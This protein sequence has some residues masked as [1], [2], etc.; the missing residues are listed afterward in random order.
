[1]SRLTIYKEN[2]SDTVAVSNQFIDHYLA[3]ANDAQI[4]V[5]LYLLR[6]VTSAIPTSISDIADKFNHTERD[7]MRALSYWEKLGLIAIEYDAK[8]EICG[9]QIPSA[10]EDR[11]GG[12]Q[13]Y[14]MRDYVDQTSVQNA[15]QISRQQ[16]QTM[17]QQLAAGMPAQPLQQMQ[18]ASGQ[19][20]QSDRPQGFFIEKR[21]YSREEIKALKEKEDFS[22][23]LFATET[24][25]A[26][27]LTKTDLQTLAFISDQLEF[28]PDLL[29][30]LVEYCVGKDH[31]DMHYIEKVAIAWKQAGIK[32]VRQAKNR[33]SRYE[34]IVYSVMKAL[35]RGQ[36]EVTQT[37]ADYILGWYHGLGFSEEVILL[38][39]QKAVLA[40]E[41][42][43]IAYTDGI[44]KNWH[45]DGLK[46]TSQI[47]K[48]E[49]KRAAAGS[50]SEG[51]PGTGIPAKRGNGVK[52]ATSG[53]VH[54][55]YAGRDI[56]FDS[57]E[58]EALKR[59]F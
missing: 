7:V 19:P 6:M 13:I 44:L 24:Y 57:L 51:T 54:L 34:K 31:R 48:A 49:E 23:V 2:A 47:Q 59:S 40:T 11:Q 39:C 29:E 55:Q 45:K 53:M 35:G 32:T 21:E 30:Y 25:F 4:K 14:A 50:G 26:R 37:E 58:K 28:S 10:G 36:N 18:A 22:Q 33:S 3:D 38:A 56:D 1:M 41:S 46:T 52:G 43:R 16:T 15:D 9:V 42:N 27:P 8:G 20:D 5:Y 12:A 17:T